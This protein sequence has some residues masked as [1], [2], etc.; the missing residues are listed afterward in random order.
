M[1]TVRFELE[2]EGLSAPVAAELEG[3]LE[4][5]LNEVRMH[6]QGEEQIF[7]FEKDQEHEFTHA[8]TRTAMSLVAH[9]V[10]RIPVT[11]NFEHHSKTMLF[12]PSATV[13]KV[14]RWATGKNGYHLDDDAR[15]K[16]NLMQPGAEAPLARDQVI[17]RLFGVGH[18]GLTLEL[19]L[20]DFTNGQC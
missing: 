13:F 20:R 15:A 4:A 19:T 1:A 11:V 6:L 12:A 14:L 7:L 9:R 3:T 2:I 17:G 18:C 8:G 10:N 5:V 16:A